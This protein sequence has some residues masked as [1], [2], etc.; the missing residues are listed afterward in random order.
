[1]IRVYGLLFLLVGVLYPPN[2]PAQTK[3]PVP[4]SS[5]PTLKVNTRLTIEYVTV[6]DAKGQNVH[7]LT[8]ADFV[9]KE[10]GKVQPLK[11]F[12]EH[13]GSQPAEAGASSQKASNDAANPESTPSR[14]GPTPR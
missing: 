2:A 14:H 12:E 4:E 3:S 6:T 7:G 9:L 5:T 11:S 10:D 8:Q 1:M 13:G